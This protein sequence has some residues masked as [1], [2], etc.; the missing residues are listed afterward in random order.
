MRYNCNNM[1]SIRRAL[2]LTISLML[3]IGQASADPK[4]IGHSRNSSIE[5]GVQFGTGGFGY[6]LPKNS[7][8][9][10]KNIASLSWQIHT[11][12][13]YFFLE[14]MGVGI[15]LDVSSFAQTSRL[16]GTLSYLDV[17][18][19]D[20]ERYT[21]RLDLDD[22]TERQNAYF[23]EIPLGLK[24]C[25]GGP[26]VY[27]IAELG[28]KVG[29]NVAASYKG[30]KGTTTHYGV[31]PMWGTE[32]EP[33]VLRDMDPHGFYTATDYHPQGKFDPNWKLSASVY[34]KI[35]MAVP[36]AEYLDM[37]FQVCAQYSL[38]DSYKAGGENELGFLNDRKGQEEAHYF[39]PE[40]SSILG[41]KYTSGAC[42]PWSVGLEIGLRY[43]FPA[44]APCY[45]CRNA[46]YYNK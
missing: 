8:L 10:A 34:G 6:K 24:F 3:V 42:R 28:A 25:G 41:T 2:L 23:V 30:I 18:D 5:M 1:I 35:G 38:T 15:G 39:L 11:G 19:T 37:T 36:V 33:L 17:T 45:P 20:G 29:F 21:H 43:T 46:Y 13:N 27:F 26:N 14:N 22:W 7:G 32:L 16:N 31:Y 40:Y 9:E 44:K 12:Y 4:R